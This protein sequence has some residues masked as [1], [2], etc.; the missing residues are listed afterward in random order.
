[1]STRYLMVIMSIIWTLVYIQDYIFFKII[2]NWSCTC[3]QEKIKQ[4]FII[5]D[6]EEQSL[7]DKIFGATLLDHYRIIYLGNF[8]YKNTYTGE[9]ITNR[10][11]INI[12]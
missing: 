1:M 11:A 9:Q 2:D 5:R 6:V 8:I 10:I 12:L 4:K 3:Q 7:H